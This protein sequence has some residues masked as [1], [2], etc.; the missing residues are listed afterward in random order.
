MSEDKHRFDLEIDIVP[1]L[2]SINSSVDS[3]GVFTKIAPNRRDAVEIQLGENFMMELRKNLDQLTPMKMDNLIILDAETHAAFDVG[4]DID[5]ELDTVNVRPVEPPSG[6]AVML[7]MPSAKGSDFVGQMNEIYPIWVKQYGE[8]R[9]R[10]I[11]ISQA[12]QAVAGHWINRC[13]ELFAKV[14]PAI[15]RKPSND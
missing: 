8:K 9:A 15:L 2:R 13:L 3:I 1:L 6:Y 14:S 4:S 10:R 7:M 11:W 12:V 5:D